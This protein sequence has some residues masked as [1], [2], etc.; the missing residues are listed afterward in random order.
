MAWPGDTGASSRDSNGKGDTIRVIGL[1]SDALADIS[2]VPPNN[3]RGA[4]PNVK[5]VASAQP[6]AKPALYV[7]YNGI[8]HPSKKPLSAMTLPPML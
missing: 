8:K 6:N 1:L 3:S 7:I 2:K 5:M 4:E